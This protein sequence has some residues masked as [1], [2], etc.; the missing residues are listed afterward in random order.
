MTIR[1]RK[2]DMDIVRVDDF[3][4]DS[5][6]PAI[7][8]GFIYCVN[9]ELTF[10]FVKFEVYMSQPLQSLELLR[11]NLLLL[12]WREPV[13]YPLRINQLNDLSHDDGGHSL[14]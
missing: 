11:I 12:V 3:V 6:C 4:G 9:F 10:V 14:A 2:S 1:T 7:D 5:P 8:L 13:N